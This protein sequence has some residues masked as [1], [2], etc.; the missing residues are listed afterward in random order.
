MRIT[1][2]TQELVCATFNLR[3]QVQEAIS[4]TAE[5]ADAIVSRGTMEQILQQH[6]EQ[7]EQASLILSEEGYYL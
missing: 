6:M 7:T 5:T 4:I 1:I 3:L 2:S